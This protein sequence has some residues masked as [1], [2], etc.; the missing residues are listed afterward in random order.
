LARCNGPTANREES[1]AKLQIPVNRLMA[2]SSTGGTPASG[3]VRPAFRAP[4]ISLVL[5][6]AKR[7]PRADRYIDF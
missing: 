5:D 2:T 4:A 1:K 3:C 7:G 6:R